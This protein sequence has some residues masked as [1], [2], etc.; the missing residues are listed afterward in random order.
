MT[1]LDNLSLTEGRDGIIKS[2][3]GQQGQGS[4]DVEKTQVIGKKRNYTKML[5]N[6]DFADDT[7]KLI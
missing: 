2:L 7:I 5:E 3:F 1:P 4:N 6:E